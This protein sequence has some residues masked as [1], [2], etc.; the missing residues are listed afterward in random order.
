MN[1][2]GLVVVSTV[3]SPALAA[4]WGKAEDPKACAEASTPGQIHYHDKCQAAI[5]KL[6]EGCIVDPE[7]KDKLAAAAGFVNGENVSKFRRD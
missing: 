1:R 5:D 6:V 2:I 4:D 7:F 3:A